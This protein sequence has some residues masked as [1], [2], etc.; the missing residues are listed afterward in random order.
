MS[1]LEQAVGRPRLE[2]GP[3]G[4]RR[5]RV[6]VRVL[7]ILFVLP[8]VLLLAGVTIFPLLYSLRLAFYSWEL[9][10]AVASQ[11]FVG[12][13]NFRRALF[14]DGRFWNA[15][16]NTALVVGL[17]VGVELALGTALALLLDRLGRLRSFVVALFMIP[18]VIAPVVAGFQWRLIYHDQA[19]PLNYLLRQAGIPTFAWLADPGVAL[20]AIVVADVWQWTPFMLL[21]MLA[22]FQSV[23]AELYEAARVDGASLWQSF[24]RI[25]VPVLL[26]I[27][28]VAL[29]VRGMDA[30]KLF[31]LVFL[32]TGGGPGS[33]TETISFYTY[34]EG[35]RFFSMGYGAALSYIQLLVIT[36]VARLFLGLVRKG[37]HAQ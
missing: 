11:N 29:L 18:V 26:P 35:F 12:L 30:F 28:L 37:G 19:G 22:G 17:G 23:P 8:S 21:L 2:I 36:I 32:L 31:D 10:S 27:I 34:L 13:A 6:R 7:P 1:R 14:E 24:W 20:L 5:P 16:R 3:R 15:M 25:T 4:R 33:T 9:S